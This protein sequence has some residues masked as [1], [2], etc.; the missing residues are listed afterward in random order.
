MKED[1]FENLKEENGKKVL[2]VDCASDMEVDRDEEK[3]EEFVKDM[4]QETTDSEKRKSPKAGIVWA[5]LALGSLL[6]YI[7]YFGYMEY[8]MFVAALLVILAL[9]NKAIK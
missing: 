8:S 7:L 3:I 4:E 5:G 6:F 2:G 9:G 1:E